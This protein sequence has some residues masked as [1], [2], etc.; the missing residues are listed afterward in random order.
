VLLGVFVFADYLIVAKGIELPISATQKIRFQDAVRA[1]LRSF[2]GDSTAD[3]WATYTDPAGIFSFN[4]PP[5]WTLFDKIPGLIS[6]APPQ[7]L[8]GEILI[9]VTKDNEYKVPTSQYLQFHNQIGTASGMVAGA[10][11]FSSGEP[12]AIVFTRGIYVFNVRSEDISDAD[13]KAILDTFKVSSTVDTDSNPKWK[14]FTADISEPYLSWSESDNAKPTFFLVGASLGDMPAPFEVPKF[15]GTGS[16]AAGEKIHALLLTLRVSDAQAEKTPVP[17]RLILDETGASAPPNSPA[18]LS[19]GR[20]PGSSYLENL[21]FVVPEDQTQFLFQTGNVS[22]KYFSLTLKDDSLS[23]EVEKTAPTAPTTSTTPS[24]QAGSSS[25]GILG[26]SVVSPKNGSIVYLVLAS[27]PS[28]GTD[29]YIRDTAGNSRLLVS[30]QGSVFSHI[31]FVAGG[32]GITFWKST[33]TGT[34]GDEGLWIIHPDGT[35]LSENAARPPS[36]TGKDGVDALL[37][38]SSTQLYIFGATLGDVIGTQAVGEI[39][40]TQY[41]AR[42]DPFPLNSVSRGGGVPS[43]FTLTAPTGVFPNGYSH[44]FAAVYDPI[45]DWYDTTYFTD[46]YSFNGRVV[47][48]IS[49]TTNAAIGHQYRVD[50]LYSEYISHPISGTITAD[51]LIPGMTIDIGKTYAF[52]AVPDSQG[53]FAVLSVGPPPIYD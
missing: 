15:P 22:D 33:P 20:T 42:S 44:S 11:A 9:Q 45:Y 21:I 26:D 49:T 16:Y 51:I 8:Q 30:G 28:T 1:S 25:S 31:E 14:E 39:A 41:Q 40:E 38:A 27:P 4:Y 23:V 12:P 52:Y 7:P 2:L 17:V 43:T 13:T 36:L 5:G 29:M 48:D 6:L 50:V 3:T 35:G 53:W 24:K 10:Q 46:L 37:A 34:P 47:S 18:F 32:D 19:P